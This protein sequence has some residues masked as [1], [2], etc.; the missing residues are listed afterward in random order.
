MEGNELGI[1]TFISK[2]PSKTPYVNS[3]PVRFTFWHFHLLSW[4][5]N[6][7]DQNKVIVV[8]GF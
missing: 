1:N 4:K 8:L 6:D 5:V 2:S 7:G 3:N